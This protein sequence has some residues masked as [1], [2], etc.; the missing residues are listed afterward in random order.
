MTS[1]FPEFSQLRVAQQAT[2]SRTFTVADLAEW[3]QLAGLDELAAAS[4]D[5][6]PEPLIAG[7]FSYLLGV[8]LPGNGTMYLKQTLDCA[9]SARPEEALTAQVTITRLRPDKGLVDLATCCTGEQG[10][11]IG[12]GHA[13]VLF[14]R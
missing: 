2:V 12:H 5:R 4:P 11:L 3:H 7:L 9:A 10:R 6:V 14:R 13:L 1:T 8:K